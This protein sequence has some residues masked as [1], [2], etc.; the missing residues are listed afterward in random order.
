[1]TWSIFWRTGAEDRK[2][3]AAEFLINICQI[4][5]KNIYRIETFVVFLIN[6]SKIKYKNIYITTLFTFTKYLP[7]YMTWEVI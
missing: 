3:R 1:M 5:Y 4:K 7:T 6:I 2:E